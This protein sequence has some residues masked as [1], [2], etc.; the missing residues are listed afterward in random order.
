MDRSISLRTTWEKYGNYC[1]QFRP[2]DSTRRVLGR[3]I[4]SIAR[5]QQGA[6]LP[7]TAR[8]HRT[9][10]NAGPWTHACVDGSRVRVAPPHGNLGGGVAMDVRKE[11]GR[12]ALATPSTLAKVR[13]RNSTA[14]AAN[15]QPAI[16]VFVGRALRALRRIVELRLKDAEPRPCLTQLYRAAD[17]L[18]S[19][20]WG[21]EYEDRLRA[22]GER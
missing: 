12:P 13:K 15:D 18:E 4:L 7:V 16:D 3:S 6:V 8:G 22:R 2:V 20:Q 14:N 11:T 1:E 17:A 21:L 10:C 9:T 19:A 5:N